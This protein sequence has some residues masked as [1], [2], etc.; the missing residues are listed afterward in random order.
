VA[1]AVLPG[2]GGGSEG[3]A[4]ADLNQV[5]FMTVTALAASDASWWTGAPAATD[6]LKRI[7]E[8]LGKL[9]GDSGSR[10]FREERDKV[11]KP[12]NLA[13]MDPE[14]REQALAAKKR[15]DN[16]VDELERGASPK[17]DDGAMKAHLATATV[18]KA[19]VNGTR[20]QMLGAWIREAAGS[21]EGPVLVMAPD[22]ANP[23]YA[24]GSRQTLGS[25][26]Y[27]VDGTV[28]GQPARVF[29]APMQ[30]VV[31][32][33]KY[34]A[35]VA[36]GSSAPASSGG[37]NPLGLVMLI[38]APL[39]VGGLAYAV[40]GGHAK[41]VR[42]VARELDRLGSSGDPT[43]SIRAHGAEASMVAKAVERMVA[44]LEFRQKHGAAD[45]DQV[46]DKEQK[47]AEEIHGALMSKNPPR[48]SD[49]EVETLFKPGFEIG[50]DHFEY[51]R[52]DEHHLGV[53]LLDTNVRGIPAALV[54]A[55]ARSYVRAAAPGELSPAAVLRQV[56]RNLAGD[57]P[58]GRHV[59]AMYVVLDTAQ[60]KATLASAG[61]LP[62]LV[63]RH[64]SGRVAKVN[65]E[66][67]ALGLDVG[68][69]F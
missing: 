45:L 65:P 60:G 1:L 2:R 9:F 25:G 69:V 15:F 24:F 67:I 3:P 30:G 14:E 62:L 40:A 41:S 61:H 10:W 28:A 56:N 32:K 6:V 19:Y 49:Y 52:I 48:L 17:V 59:T 11:T 36:V 44:N 35:Y 26:L 42:E 33:K 34:T 23:S 21:G 12:G 20:F 4:D 31:D 27:F 47:V 18:N 29:M 50:G 5:G 55:S 22:G 68:P 58:P 66:G 37:G 7:E 57:L 16:A 54:M 38:L 13:G 64:A 53:I 8:S 46:V 43:R 63:Y 51:F 39:V